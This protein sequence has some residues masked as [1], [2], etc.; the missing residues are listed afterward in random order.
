LAGKD[1][2]KG[3]RVALQHIKSN[4]T[5]SKPQTNTACNMGFEKLIDIWKKIYNVCLPVSCQ[6]K[7]HLQ[8][9]FEAPAGVVAS[10]CD[11]FMPLLTA[12][13]EANGT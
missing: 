4:N 10:D 13:T 5:F 11:G 3:N 8:E 12:R 2:N 1:F 7:I 6:V 9:R